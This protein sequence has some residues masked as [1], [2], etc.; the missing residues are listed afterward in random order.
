MGE[1]VIREAVE[2]NLS[3]LYM[4]KEQKAAVLSRVREPASAAPARIRFSAAMVLA[5]LLFLLTVGAVA[6]AFLGGKD[7][8]KEVVAPMAK[9]SDSD[10]F[11][12]DEVEEIL[13]LAKENE[14]S[15]PQYLW[16]HW[17]RWGSEYKEEVMRALVKTELGFYPGS[18]S[19]EDQNWYNR[20]LVDCGLSEGV[21]CLVPGEEDFS[22]EYVLYRANTVFKEKLGLTG[23]VNDTQKYRRFL[24]FGM[25]ATN[26]KVT[27][28]QWCV[29]YEDLET[30]AQ[31]AFMM[32]DNGLVTRISRYQ[33][34]AEDTYISALTEEDV[35]SAFRQSF[36]NNPLQW[37]MEVLE[38]F[39]HSFTMCDHTEKT[40]DP[41]IRIVG[42]TRYLLPGSHYTFMT[43]KE[44]IQLAR[45]ACK[46][47]DT[48][49]PY[50]IYFGDDP[51]N[52]HWKIS[53]CQDGETGREFLLYA[54]ID[55]KTG[56]TEYA[57]NYQDAPW[58]APLV[59]AGHHAKDTENRIFRTWET[60]VNWRSP[61]FP[62]AYWDALEALD[63]NAETRKQRIEEWN[64]EYGV[65][66]NLWPYEQ[67]AVY[68]WW[69]VNPQFDRYRYHVAGIPVEGEHLPV[70]EA[71]QIALNRFMEEAPA[72]FTQEELSRVQ[73]LPADFHYRVE[74]GRIVAH[75]WYFDIQVPFENGQY[76]DSLFYIDAHTGDIL[77][78]EISAAP[79]NG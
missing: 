22:Q 28:K 16:E 19:L 49:S 65:H 62:D 69:E 6:A 17:A 48:L 36:G 23:D 70:E 18:W 10:S 24:T 66:T 34:G 47:D 9:E 13:R 44:A 4:T 52:M 37:N 32:L 58:Y 61:L 51:S 30:G 67:Q 75:V 53:F 26:P 74:D 46:A 42:Q 29:E 71:R 54:Q 15:V 64:R 56:D 45:T 1:H 55:G 57:G 12:A 40:A 14:I 21:S 11:T 20:M 73:V 63:Y 78:E 50:V 79:G 76:S 31:Y 5:L 72:L 25:D 60:P 27:F 3:G 68:W 8:T 41:G 59:S 39:Y 33:A 2:Q 35:V 7:F 77:E 38:Q 43:E